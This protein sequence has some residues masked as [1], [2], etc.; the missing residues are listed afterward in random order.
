MGKKIGLLTGGGDAPGNNAVIM[1]VVRKALSCGFEPIGFKMGWAGPLKCEY[2]ALYAT[3]VQDIHRQGGTILGSSRT[4]LFKIE[5]GPEKVL[6]NL[7][8]LDIYALIAIGGEDTQG[9]AKRLYELG[10]N[11]VGVP[12]TI[13]NDLNATD[14]TFGFDTAIN[15][16]TEAIDR[17][18]STTKAHHRVMVVEV[19]GRH[20]GWMTLYGG[21]AGGAHF[22]L[23]PEVEFDAGD[24]CTQIKKRQKLG[25]V[26]TIIAIAEGAVSQKLNQFIEHPKQKDDFGHVRLGSGITVGQALE[27]YIK[28]ETESE[29]RSVVLGH[30]QRGGSPSAFDRILATKLGIKAVELVVEGQF[31]MMASLQGNQIVGVKLADAVGS[32]KTVSQD[33]YNRFKLF[34]G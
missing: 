29:V 22:I 19:M 33:E 34:L 3:D 18:H 32:L 13:D 7:K 1:A 31:G 26:Y 25:K 9:V 16:V 2:Q 27:K 6:E 24:L 20:A 5:K 11:V 15:R 30:T 8:K 23:I 14:Y 28:K 4:N 10:A 12:K 21:F 17:L